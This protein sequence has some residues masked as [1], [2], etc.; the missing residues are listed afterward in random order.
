[1]YKKDFIIQDGKVPVSTNAESVIRLEN[2]KGAR[3]SN[4]NAAGD[5][6]AFIKVEGSKSGKV[7]V[8]KNN[9]G[10]TKKKTELAAEVAS[11]AVVT[12]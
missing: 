11:E 3:I 6:E 10:S 7:R 1:M 9:I 12:D 5:T 4:I 8:S 2:V